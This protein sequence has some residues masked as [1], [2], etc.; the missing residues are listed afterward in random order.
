MCNVFHLKEK[1][2]TAL[3]E[4]QGFWEGDTGEYNILHSLIMP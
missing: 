3:W 1:I 2:P 4:L